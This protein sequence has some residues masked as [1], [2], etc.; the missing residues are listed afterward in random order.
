[1][2]KN[3]PKVL[4]NGS[5]QGFSG[6]IGNLIFRQL[7]DGTTVVS[8]APPKKSRRQ[9]KRDK[10]KRSPLQK[11]HNSNFKDAAAY[12]KEAAK[13]HPVYAELAAELP[14]ITAYN[15]AQ[16][17]W[18]HPPEI[19]RVECKEGRILV[20][21]TDN[22]LVTKVQVTIL[23]DEEQVLEKG[24]AIRGEGSWWEFAPH[25]EGRTIVAEAW[26]LPGHVTKFV[27]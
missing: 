4:F 9:K 10:L 20:E 17:D 11:A 6:R 15:A 12:A 13:V 5:I 16:S 8:E 25:T 22:V 14:M 3:M 23:G 18:W 7:P 21:A 2:E 19:H 1:M 24:E 26:D 27:L